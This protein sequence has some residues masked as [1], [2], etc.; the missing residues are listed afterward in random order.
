MTNSLE[1]SREAFRWLLLPI[2]VASEDA[3]V[4][5]ALE[6]MESLGV[7][8]ADFPA[9]LELQVDDWRRAGKPS[10]SLKGV[11]CAYIEA[12]DKDLD[13]LLAQKY[14]ALHKK[15]TSRPRLGHDDASALLSHA[16][17]IFLMAST[18]NLSASQIAKL[19]AARDARA[20]VVWN[21]VQAILSGLGLKL[22]LQVASVESLD[23]ADRK[24]EV[25]VF[26]DADESICMEMV[27][28]AG[29]RLAFPGDL[30]RDLTILLPSDA[31]PL[32]PYLQML[33]YQCA[34]AEFFDHDLSALY[35]FSPRGAI[36][37][38]LLTRYP[39]SLNVSKNAFLNLAK[40]V[41]AIDEDWARRKREKAEAYALVQ[42]VSGLANMGFAARRELASWIRRLLVR[43]IRLAG[44]AA[45]K[46]PGSLSSQEVRR[47]LDAVAAGETESRGILEQRVLD[48]ACSL[49]HLAPDWIARGLGDSVNATNIS[50]RK[51]GD[52]DFQNSDSRMVVAYEAHAGRLSDIY[53]EA[54]LQTLGHVLALRE[55]EWAENVGTDLA[56]TVKVIFVAH[57]L[58]LSALQA[59]VEAGNAVVEIEAFS[60]EEL[61]GSLDEKQPEVLDAI[62]RYVL[63]PLS[64]E[65]TPDSIRQK[66][67]DLVSP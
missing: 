6:A 62:Q 40:S 66:L 42:I 45:I 54:H 20:P 44:K 3:A 58:A 17:L 11:V 46:L 47:L 39:S 23:D 52:C 13:L 64:R 19:I 14:F 9:W 56:W 12:G 5:A 2:D 38:W 55:Q 29:Q 16:R 28:Q 1:K 53:V 21:H 59:P 15:L 24:I 35:E 30:L 36:A 31:T 60:F 18:E 7:D 50:R 22:S 8:E 65:R 34:L 32:G 4:E 57:E 25:E 10:R 41:E 49:L 37:E 33:H 48:A 61:L 27:A 26:A 63:E 51:C 67:L 43:R